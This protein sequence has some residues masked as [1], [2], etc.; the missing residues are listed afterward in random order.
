MW[1]YEWKQTNILSDVTALCHVRWLDNEKGFSYFRTSNLFE[2]DCQLET[3]CSR[4]SEFI[5]A[6]VTSLSQTAS[7]AERGHVLTSCARLR[8]EQFKETKSLQIFENHF[9]V[10]LLGLVQIAILF[11]LT[12]LLTP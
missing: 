9:T 2:P 8:T 7:S 1:S 6:D 5:L 12:Y 4:T 10:F 3:F 11:V